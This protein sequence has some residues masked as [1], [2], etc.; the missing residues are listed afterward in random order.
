M[1]PDEQV[2]HDVEK[3][4]WH[5]I[6][7][8]ADAEGPSFAY[9]IGL[10]ERYGHPEIIVFG[11]PSTVTHPVLNQIGEA[12]K[13]GQ[14][15]DPGSAS[16]A[17][18]EG[19]ACHFVAFPRAQYRAFLGYALWFYDGDG[20]PAVQCVWPDRAGRF[21]WSGSMEADLKALQPVFAPPQ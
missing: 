14:R 16:D 7:V 12:V 5:V 19:H 8:M 4:G 13:S 11:L 18:L 17:F 20:F 6:H 3:Y 10:T 15:F 9:T 21:P 2:V 1:T